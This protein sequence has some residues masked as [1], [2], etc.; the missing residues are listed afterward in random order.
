MVSDQSPPPEEFERLKARLEFLEKEVAEQQQI[1]DEL[2]ISER[3]FRSVFESAAVGIAITDP[4]HNITEANDTFYEMLGYTPAVPLKLNLL[5]LT[6]AEDSPQVESL[7]AEV[8]E[9]LRDT[10]HTE[11]RLIHSNSDPLWVRIS[12]SKLLTEEE[13]SPRLVIVEDITRQKNA[14]RTLENLNYE[15]IRN[16]EERASE[17][18]RIQRRTSAILDNS[19]DAI[20]LLRTDGTANTGNLSFQRQFGYHIDAFVRQSIDILIDESDRADFLAALKS[21]ADEQTTELREVKALRMDNTTFDAAVVLAPF[22]VD[23]KV[24]GIICSFRDITELKTVDRLKDALVESITHEINTPIA[25]LKLYHHLLR[26]HPD[27]TDIYLDTLDREVSRLQHVINEMLVMSQIRQDESAEW[28]STFNMN[29]VVEILYTDRVALA[30]ERGLTLDFLPANEE[31]TID[32]DQTMIEQ[33][34]GRLLSNAFLYTPEGGTVT[35]SLDRRPLQGGDYACVSVADTG[36]GLS[37]E[38]KDA[39]FERF[40]RGQASERTHVGGTGLGLA[41]AK[42]IIE[43]HGGAVYATS[44]GINQG[45]EFTIWLPLAN[46]TS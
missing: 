45:S 6:Q 40:Y 43:K 36:L 18:E 28:D 27:R 5:T 1:I 19:P 37:G 7:I 46:R 26:H 24:D 15:L 8:E 14:L 3:L 34:V 2:V 25:N 38:D 41:I 22:V 4:A 11:K 17:F 10:F 30:K 44:P 21:A 29:Q 16:V 33:A 13:K 12:Y 35:L 9:G 32:G 23:G 39:L 20:L 42:Q 31:L